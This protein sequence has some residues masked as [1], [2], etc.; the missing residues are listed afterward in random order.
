MKRHIL[1]LAA[2]LLVACNRHAV[3]DGTYT[4][5]SE[6]FS[7]NGPVTCEVTFDNGRIADVRVI[8]E[9]DSRTSDIASMAFNIF[10][11][12]L[13][14]SQNLGTDAVTG[15]TWTSN[16]I[17]NCTAKAIKQAGGDI[18]EWYRKE[19]KSE[20]QVK[21]KGYDVIV[22]GLGGSGIYAYA[23]AAFAGAKVFGIE[24]AAKLGGQSAVVSGPMALK[25]VNAT[26]RY[27]PGNVT[28][29]ELFNVW[30]EYAGHERE[31]IIR[32]AIDKSGPTL[33]FY[34]D[35]FGV[36]ILRGAAS[37]TNREWHNLWFPFVPDT[38]T[39]ITTRNKTYMFQAIMDK[40]VAAGN[41]NRYELELTA[42]SLITDGNNR[43]CGV[44]A[45]KRDGTL[46]RIYGKCVILATGGYIGNRD[47][48]QQYLGDMPA[49]LA[50]T[51]NDGA[52]IKMA[53]EAG[54]A[55]YNI[56]A[57]PIIHIIQVPNL[58]RNNDLS[59]EQKGILTALAL[60]KDQ[61]CV[62]T[63]GK[64][65]D[66]REEIC[67]APGFKYYVIFPESTITQFKEKGLPASYEG[68]TPRVINQ[69]E[70]SGV[71]ICKP[72]DSIHTILDVGIRYGN[73][74]KAESIAELAEKLSCT[75]RELEKSLQG[76]EGTYY[77]VIA[78]GYTYGTIGGLDVDSDCHVLDIRGKP[79]PNLFAAGND[80]LGVE[81]N[82][83]KPYTPWGGI[84]HSW[85]M[86]SGYI[87]GTNA[88]KLNSPRKNKWRLFR[89]NI[90]NKWF[91]ANFQLS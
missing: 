45:E 84:A 2:I 89:P 81:N 56:A 82:E 55:T 20:S 46:C 26:E 36:D 14:S 25:S 12:R 50:Y 74:V 86:T 35:N 67:L 49:T 63:E 51:I 22:V 83:G 28:P 76:K 40:A 87:A 47:M 57:P 38:T 44:L 73:V 34:M 66:V 31:D 88:F 59:Q 30:T 23:A 70:P 71:P 10:I 8:E 64:V 13:I 53:T 91:F 1:L 19:R 41:G 75:T 27:G 61:L 4:T 80:C 29:E 5:Q 16:A 60:A 39:A 69:T 18:S 42:K 37:I 6:S 11:P 48:V 33:D 21:E 58:I 72:I 79:I 3:Q 65:W 77:A 68:N 17:R 32:K 85:A 54:A 78:A 7:W 24:K 9:Y 62:T 90:W 43:I 52:G 15:A